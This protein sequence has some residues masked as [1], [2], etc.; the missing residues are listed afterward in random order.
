MTRNYLW[1]CFDTLMLAV[2]LFAAALGGCARVAHDD[3]ESG[4][5][6]SISS[7]PAQLGA[8]R[9]ANAAPRRR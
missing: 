7:R 2:I 5:E 3:Y 1:N 4:R 9:A 6:R 8:G